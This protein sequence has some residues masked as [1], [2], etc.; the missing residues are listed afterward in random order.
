MPERI[1]PILDSILMTFISLGI[2]ISSLNLITLIPT[3][4][5]T[6]FWCGKIKSIVDSKYNGS[7]LKYLKSIL[8]KKY[9]K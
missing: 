7:F 4:L 8:K 2:F 3:F 9:N 5:A 6:L 1:M